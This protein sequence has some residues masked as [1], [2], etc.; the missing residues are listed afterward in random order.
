MNKN[1]DIEKF[2]NETSFKVPEGYF[3]ELKSDIQKQ[4]TVEERPSFVSILKLQFITPSMAVVLV[5][6]FLYNTNT[7]TETIVENNTETNITNDDLLAYLEDVNE[8]LIYEY[9]TTETEEEIDDFLIEQY[10]YN[11][12]IYEL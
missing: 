4:C 3:S 9:I 2:E 1:I 6:F 8:E 10:D 5:L 12:L 11:D 7:T